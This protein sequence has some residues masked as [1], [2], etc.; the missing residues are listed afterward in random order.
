[1]SKSNIEWT[2]FT[3]NPTTGCNK[4][5]AG[6]KFCY[7]EALSKILKENGQKKY[8]NGIGFTIHPETL[9][10]PYNWKEPKTVFVNSMSDLF[11][12]DMPLDFLKQVFEVMNKTPQHTYQILTKR[13]EK[14]VH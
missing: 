10:H 3:W 6:C 2:D 1:M 12:E 8:R 9:N 11:H 4:V 13:P 7:A 5:S 14:V